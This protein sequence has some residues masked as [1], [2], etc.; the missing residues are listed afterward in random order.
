M[1]TTP[2]EHIGALKPGYSYKLTVKF[3]F[4]ALADNTYQGDGPVNVA[5]TVDAFQMARAALP[6][7]LRGVW[8]D[9]LSPVGGWFQLQLNK[10]P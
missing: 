8:D 4:A 9:P 2:Y 1:G 7:A 10:Q 6:V 3:G 5:L